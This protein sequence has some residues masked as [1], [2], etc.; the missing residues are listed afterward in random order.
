MPTLLATVGYDGTRFSGWQRQA[1]QRTV[2]KCVEQAL[3]TVAR[4]PVAVRVAGRTDAGVHARG[5]RIS[6]RWQLELP[7]DKLLRAMTALLPDDIVISALDT[8]PDDFEIKRDNL[9][10]QYVYRIHS[11]AYRPLFL[12]PYVWHWRGQLDIDAMRSA[13][14]HLVGEKDFDSFRNAGCQ[15]KHAHRTIWSLGLE[16]K[17]ELL[18]IEVRGNAF[19]RGMVRV[20]AGTLM[21][22]GRGRLAAQDIP[23]ILE[24][25]DRRCAGVTA[26]AKGLTLERVYLYEEEV[27]AEIPDWASWPGF[28]RP[29]NNP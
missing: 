20:I 1:G 17:Q 11:A 12:R 7:L 22:V 14:A 2:Q 18:E 25:R 26:P 29:F 13:A 27:Q 16:Q 10:K 9:G 23:K 28:R 3:S 24:A 4:M 21:D 19:V 8:R 6:C 15:D 5:Q